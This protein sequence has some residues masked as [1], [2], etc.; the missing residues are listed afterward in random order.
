M[1]R[2]WIQAVALAL[3]MTTLASC[4][5]LNTF[6]P[7]I[8]DPL[9]V[10]GTEVTLQ[11]D[12]IAT[13]QLSPRQ[14]SASSFTGTFTAE[15]G[16]LDD[17][18]LDPRSLKTE[19]GFDR[20]ALV[21]PDSALTEAAFP[22]TLTVTSI[23]LTLAVSDDEDPAG[24]SFSFDG[25]ELSVAFERS[26]C[27]VVETSL[28]CPYLPSADALQG[29]ALTFTGDKFSTLFDVLTNGSSPNVF[30]GS[31][32]VTFDPALDTQIQI[33]VATLA[34]TDGRITVF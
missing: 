16:D 13:S 24:V 18:P 23:A 15:I 4:G 33:A 29:L 12:D 6:V 34:T 14:T 17:P 11:R 26:G 19:L 25:P 1:N 8:E 32:S 30:E 31:L 3:L 21:G 28:A 27:Q 7:P 9:G 10:N 2:R 5:L 22:E 20:I